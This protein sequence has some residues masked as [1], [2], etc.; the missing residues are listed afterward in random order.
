MPT[1]TL[2]LAALAAATLAA[3]ACGRD[4]T[5]P[6]APTDPPPADGL[7]PRLLPTV[8][9]AGVVIPKTFGWTLSASTV[10]LPASSC[11][12]SDE[13]DWTYTLVLTQDVIDRINASYAAGG[14]PHV[15]VAYQ[16]TVEGY[17][18]LA[19]EE[20]V[21]I[22][23]NG[24]QR[25]T[26]G[27]VDGRAFPV[28]LVELPTSYTWYIPPFQAAA[29]VAGQYLEVTAHAEVTALENGGAPPCPTAGG[30]VTWRG[31]GASLIFD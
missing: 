28:S 9:L 2:T 27:S 4:T 10:G 29:F 25:F 7:A 24:A 21:I 6:R 8:G 15:T 20:T 14:L 17:G 18:G 3:A 22:R 1:R 26:G 16:T 13:G 23:V 5:A 11:L 31:R 12:V 30:T 19:R